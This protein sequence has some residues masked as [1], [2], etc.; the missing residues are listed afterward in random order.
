M[1][2]QYG[3]TG[4]PMRLQPYSR[5]EAG[6]EAEHILSVCYEKETQVQIISSILNYTTNGIVALDRNGL[7]TSMNESARQILKIRDTDVTGRNY[8]EL[9]PH[10]PMAG[11]ALKGESTYRALVGQGSG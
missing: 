8:V 10:L 5:L 7:V 3:L 6:E 9:F 1:A 2:P 11:A 4:I